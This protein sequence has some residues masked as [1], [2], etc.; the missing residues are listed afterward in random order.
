VWY[1]H[2]SS[3]AHVTVSTASGIGKTVTANC[4]EGDWTGTDLVT[5]LPMPDAVDTVT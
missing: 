2:P 1:L 5:V 3:G 4:R